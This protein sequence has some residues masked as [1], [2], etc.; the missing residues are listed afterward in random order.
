MPLIHFII[1]IAGLLVLSWSASRFVT[2]ASGLAACFGIQPML[3]GM[4]I[5]AMGSSAP[6]I[7]VAISASLNVNNNLA[8]GN[9]IGSNIAN[10]GLVLGVTALLRPMQVASVTLKREIPMV[11]AVSV[12]AALLLADSFLSRIEGVLLLVLFFATIGALIWLSLS[13]GQS[14]PLVRELTADIESH[15]K[16]MRYLL[17]L[18]L[19]SILLPISAHYMVDSATAIARFYEISDLI[20]GLT[21]VAVGTSLPELAACIASVV[22][23]EQ[24]LALGN[25]LGSNIF[26]ILA[27]LAMPAL[28]SPDRLDAQIMQRDIP[29]MLLLTGLLIFFS[30]AI[31]G[32]RRIENWQGGLLLAGFVAFQISLF[33]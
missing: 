31:K 24:D 28:I 10:I 2:G 17:W 32:K 18:L 5:M 26:N 22:K 14:D 15:H 33:P 1:F 12:F 6:E 25:I 7:L 13:A 9:A 4:T 21:I 3:I 16:P 11:L 20:I 23:K 8:V 27:V 30:F 29:V 19:G